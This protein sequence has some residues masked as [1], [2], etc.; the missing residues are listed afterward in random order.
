[1]CSV[2]SNCLQPPWTVAHQALLS[3][4]FPRQ[5]HWSG[6][7]FPSLGHFLTKDQTQ[8]F[9]VSRI[10]ADNLPDILPLRHLAEPVK[11]FHTVNVK[12][13]S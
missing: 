12:E 13:D 4:G 8:V 6:L 11:I 9:Y 10:A 3:V 5:E 1:M 2:A 7:P